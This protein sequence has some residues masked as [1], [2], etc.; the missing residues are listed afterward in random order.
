MIVVQSNRGRIFF[1][2]VY[3]GIGMTFIWNTLSTSIRSQGDIVLNV[4]SSG[5][6]SLLLPGGR[7]THSRFAV[8]INIVE[9]STCNIMPGSG[10]AELIRKSKLIIWDKAHMNNMFCFEALDRSIKDILR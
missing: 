7:M 1:L 4:S 5:I 2:Y 10:L 3:G 8:P 6:A 9:S